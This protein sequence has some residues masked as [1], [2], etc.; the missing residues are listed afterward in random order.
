MS[1]EYGLLAI[2]ASRNNVDRRANQ[3]FQ[4]ADIRSRISR[5][6][7]QR[8]QAHGGLAPA[9]QRL[10]DRP[11]I[12]V[13]HGIDR[14]GHRLARIIGIAHA[15]RDF[16]QSV[17]HIELGQAQ[18]RYRIDVHRCAQRHRIEPA[19]ASRA[20]CRGTKFVSPLG[21]PETGLVKQLSRERPGAHPRGV[22]LGDTEHVIQKQ[23]AKP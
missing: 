20:P 15:D 12:L 22:G 7:V 5:Q 1:Q 9:G 14:V 10:V 2:G 19:A 6:R 13:V 23:W 11:Q 8:F 18:A 4:P 16:L 17:Q 21:Q 3:R